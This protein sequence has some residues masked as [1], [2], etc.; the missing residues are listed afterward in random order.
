MI[1][2]QNWKLINEALIEERITDLY[3]HAAIAAT[4]AVETAHT[5]QPI[6]EFGNNAYFVKMY[7]ENEKLR[8]QLGNL[9][10]NDAVIY[11]G[12]GF[13]QLTGRNNYHKATQAIGCPLVDRPELAM[14][15]DIA[16]KIIAWFWCSHGFPPLIAEVINQSDKEK[17]RLC[18]QA[19]R[20]HYNGGLNGFDSFMSTLALL[21]AS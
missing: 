4:I 15:P 8:H 10:P 19:V 20:R 11:C 17:R 16:A 18:W 13:A 6:K 12:K 2:Q 21:Q 7:W 14:Q 5:F 1:A 3:N 9:S